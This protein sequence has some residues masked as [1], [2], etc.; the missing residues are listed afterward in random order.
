MN[1][2]Q[3]IKQAY[4]Y[5]VSMQLKRMHINTIDEMREGCDIKRLSDEQIREVKQFYKTNFKVDVNTKW[6]EYYYSVNGVFSPMYMPTY[7]Y[8]NKIR[9]TYRTYTD[10]SPSITD[11]SSTALNRA[12]Q[13]APDRRRLTSALCAPTAGSSG[14]GC[15]AR[16]RSQCAPLSLYYVFPTC[17]VFFFILTQQKPQRVLLCGF[18][19]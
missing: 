19:D 13:Q 18:F 4:R 11:D 5:Y 10:S 17:L 6:H 12:N 7:L 9:H 3:A 15:L 8:Y 1:I 14:S 2:K 16:A